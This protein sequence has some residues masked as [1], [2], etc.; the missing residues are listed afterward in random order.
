MTDRDISTDM[1]HCRDETVMNIT[2]MFIFALAAFQRNI[3]V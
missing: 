3:F 2:E 1:L